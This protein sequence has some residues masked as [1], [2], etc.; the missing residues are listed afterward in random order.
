MPGNR[1]DRDVDV[2]DEELIPQ[3]TVNTFRSVSLQ[4]GFVFPVM[5]GIQPFNV[6]SGQDI[7]STLSIP[8]ARL[9]FRQIPIPGF[10]NKT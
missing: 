1:D 2:P 7:L 4:Q 6:W 8:I 3:L 9:V 5:E 10:G